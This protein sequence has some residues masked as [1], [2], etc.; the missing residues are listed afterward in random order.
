MYDCSRIG[1]FYS[2]FGLGEYNVQS[3]DDE[4][5]VTHMYVCQVNNILNFTFC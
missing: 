1:A 3:L 4:N 2:P 5:C